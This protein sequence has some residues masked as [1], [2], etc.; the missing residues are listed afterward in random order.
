MHWPV[1]TASLADHLPEGLILDTYQGQAWISVVPFVLERVRPRGLPAVR[2]VSDFAELNIR[3]YVLRDGVPG[4]YFLAIEAGS[5]VGTWIAKNLSG[6]P[7]SYAR[8]EHTNHEV[9]V[10]AGSRGVQLQLGYSVGNSMASGPLDVWLTERYA[11]HQVTK[12]KLRTYP[13][14]HQPW[15]LKQLSLSYF[16]FEYPQF[17]SLVEGPPVRM[18]YSEGVQVHAWDPY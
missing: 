11:I 8:I 6:L 3:T 17:E 2:G 5:K 7:Y 14:Q 4:V 1:A 13:A 15:Q 16:S 18:A 12:G 10:K 9:S